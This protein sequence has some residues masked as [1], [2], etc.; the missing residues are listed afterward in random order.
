MKFSEI[1]NFAKYVL[2]YVEQSH[3]EIPLN[4]DIYIRRIISSSLAQNKV[5]QIAESSNIKLILKLGFMP[6]LPLEY[7]SELLLA[8]SKN[9]LFVMKY[10]NSAEIIF[11]LDTLMKYEFTDENYQF[12]YDFFDN[13]FT[14]ADENV[15]DISKSL[16]DFV[17]HISNLRRNKCLFYHLFAFTTRINSIIKEDGTTVNLKKLFVDFM[18]KL[19][20]ILPPSCFKK[21]GHLK[22][23]LIRE[24]YNCED[25]YD[26]FISQQIKSPKKH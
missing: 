19:I 22:V 2:K 12:I 4:P 11:V 6:T 13:I 8:I 26:I 23:Q 5:L 16:V 25:K 20:S 24:F 7:A 17:N 9:V 21:N 3:I 1:Y 18:N 10:L 14:T 15:I